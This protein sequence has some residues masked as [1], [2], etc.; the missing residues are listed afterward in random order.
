MRQMRPSITWASWLVLLCFAS[1]PLA[2]KP[3]KPGDQLAFGVE[4]AKRGLWNEAYFR[5]EQ[6]LKLDPT[7]P[8]IL[9]NLAVAAEARGNF[10]GALKHYQEAL[11][12]AGSDIEIKRNYARFVEFYQSF[13]TPSDTG[14]ENTASSESPSGDG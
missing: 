7:N 1:V 6:A 9:N 3:I 12:L 14:A 4:M 8:R 13:K 5:F 10:E 11:R 2:A